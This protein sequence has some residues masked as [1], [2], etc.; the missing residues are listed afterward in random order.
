MQYRR[1]QRF[2]ISR[3][4]R[5]PW[6]FCSFVV[7][8]IF[9]YLMLNILLKCLMEILLGIIEHL[10]YDIFW[11]SVKSYSSFLC[12]ISFCSACHCLHMNIMYRTS[13]AP[14]NIPLR[15]Y[16]K[17]PYRFSFSVALTMSATRPIL[18]VTISLC[19][20]PVLSHSKPPPTIPT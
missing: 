16:S 20:Q 6:D 9:I 15:S 11:T 5:L 8:I 13:N 3:N 19:R 2:W 7:E 18:L 1:F 10:I 4:W 14:V 17:S 12:F